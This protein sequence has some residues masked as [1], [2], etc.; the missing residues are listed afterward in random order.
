MKIE[1]IGSG[2][3]VCKALFCNVLE[4]LRET[5]KKGRV[6]MVNDFQK[7]MKYGLSSSSGPRNLRIR[8]YP[9]VLAGYRL[10]SPLNSP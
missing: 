7:I 6:V 2:G 9:L 1:I 8:R 5:G 10:P 4:A 3:A